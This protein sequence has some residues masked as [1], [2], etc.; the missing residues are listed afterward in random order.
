L[1]TQFN[2][3]EEE[4][5]YFSQQWKPQ[6]IED[7]EDFIYPFNDDRE[8]EKT[9][10]TV[11]FRPD[12]IKRLKF[13]SFEN[14]QSI[15]AIVIRATASYLFSPDEIESYST[16]KDRQ[17]AK[18][19]TIYMSPEQRDRHKV[20]AKKIGLSTNQLYRMCINGVL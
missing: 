13:A 1:I 14:E 10:Y 11:Y 15:S 19:T 18:Q 4:Q 17:G 3:V 20:L 5:Q 8:S 6:Q 16:Q 9:A 7:I 2:T 12:E